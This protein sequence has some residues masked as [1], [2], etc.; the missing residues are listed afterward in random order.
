MDADELKRKL[1]E[2]L[3]KLDSNHGFHATCGF[4]T[5]SHGD[6]RARCELVVAPAVQN[7]SGFLHG[8]ATASLVDHAGTLAII[9]ADRE[10]RP[11]VTTD[12]NVTYLAPAPGGSTVVAD[13]VALKVGKTLAFVSVDIRR[14]EDGVLVA[15]GRMTKFQG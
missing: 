14:A 15:Q 6:G 2:R 13:A 7:I 11:G 5:V 10:A 1:A 12:L 3:A 8:G 4:K 9:T